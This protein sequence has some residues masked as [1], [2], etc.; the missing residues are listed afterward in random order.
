MGT[1]RGSEGGGGGGG[2]WGWGA[3]QAVRGSCYQK[4]RVDVYLGGG[5]R[6]ELRWE[7]YWGTVGVGCG[8]GRGGGD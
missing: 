6:Q 3:G 5:S 7:K 8:E 4:C 2:L 1:G